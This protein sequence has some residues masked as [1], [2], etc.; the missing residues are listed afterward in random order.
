MTTMELATYCMPED[1]ASLALS[2]GYVVVRAAFYERGFGVPSH[3]F[4]HSLLQF[5]GLELH[6]LTHLVI[7]HIATFVTLCE[8]YMA[9]EPHFDLWSYLFYARLQQGPDTETMALGYVD[10]H[11]RSGSRNDP[12]LCL[13]MSDP[14]VGWRKAWFL[15]RNDA[16]VSLPTLTSDR[17]I[18]HPNWGHDVAQVDLR[19]LQPLLKII[20]GMLQR[21]IMGT[22]I[23]RTLSAAGFNHFIG[24]K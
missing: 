2:L 10:L 15:L 8:A 13:P 21:G 1:H 16:D 6:H 20:Q 23:L 11:L 24:E 22:E 3:W 9:I 18:P 12:Y 4:L 17:P 14:P 19:R 5:Y 7:L